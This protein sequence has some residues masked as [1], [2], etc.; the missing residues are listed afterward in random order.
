VSAC[1]APNNAPCQTFTLFSTAASLW[2]L[3][4][5]S[6]SSQVVTTGQTFQPLVMR[7]TDGSL[8]ANPVM[9]VNVVFET[10]LAQVSPGVGGQPDGDSDAGANGMPIILGSSQAQVVTTQDG[11]ASIVP[12][13]GNVGPCDVFIAVIAGAST[14]QFEMESLAAIVRE[15]PK[16]IRAKA[17]VPAPGT[18]S[19]LQTSASQSASVP[20]F[21]VPQ[22]DLSTDPVADSHVSTCSDP[23][24]DDACSDHGRQA[25][26]TPAA[27]AMT[28]KDVSEP[29]PRSKPARG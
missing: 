8:A 16:N 2:T 5:V 24:A 12:S 21:A 19:D 27:P 1:V 26:S 14:T 11:L 17:P 18:H 6:G 25:T 29:G 9:G 28:E 22:G 10:T 7:V 4:T 15:Q 13:A 20:L 23:T 3:E